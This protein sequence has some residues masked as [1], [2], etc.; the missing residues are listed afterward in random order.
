LLHPVWLLGDTPSLSRI[1]ASIGGPDHTDMDTLAVI[2]LAF[3]A[4][5]GMLCATFRYINF[6]FASSFVKSSKIIAS[7]TVSYG[8]QSRMLTAFFAFSSSTILIRGMIGERLSL[9]V[10]RSNAVD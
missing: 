2:K 6:V 1:T 4:F 10:Y 9:G 7:L 8:S 5:T 3:F